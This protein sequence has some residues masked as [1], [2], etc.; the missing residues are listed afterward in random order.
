M[1]TLNI[2][3]YGGWYQYISVFLLF[4]DWNYVVL[5]NSTEA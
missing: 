5:I 4:R 2:R 3:I 1:K